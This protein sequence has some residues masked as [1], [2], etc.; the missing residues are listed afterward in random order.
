MK[1]RIFS[2]LLGT[3]AWCGIAQAQDVSIPLV[4]VGDAWSWGGKATQGVANPN[5]TAG[6]GCSATT[7]AQFAVTGYAAIGFNTSDANY[8]AY[9]SD[10]T[11]YDKVEF[12]IYSDVAGS[13]SSTVGI[14]GYTT[15]NVEIDAAGALSPTALVANQ[16]QI[17]TFVIP[18]SLIDKN[19]NSY[20]S[21]GDAT[22][23]LN[24]FVIQTSFNSGNIYIGAI[25]VKEKSAK[26]PTS[27]SLTPTSVSMIT[28]KTFTVTPTI[29]PSDASVTLNFTSS[30]T[31]ASVDA[32]GNVT[33]V[34]AG[35]ATITAT[36]AIAPSVSATTS[37]TISNPISTDSKVYSD[38][39]N[40]NAYASAWGTPTI[41]VVANPSKTTDNSSDSVLSVAGCIQWGAASF[42]MIDVNKINKISFWVYSATDIADFALKVGLN[43]SIDNT[44]SKAL[45]AGTWTKFE[46]NI[47]SQVFTSLTDKNVFYIQNAADGA[48]TTG[49]NFLIDDIQLIAGSSFTAVSSF[50][51]DGTGNKSSLSQTATLQMVT[52]NVLPAGVTNSS[53]VWSVSDPKVATI[54]ASTGLLTAVALGSVTVSAQADG[55]GVI[56]K[57]VIVIA[58]QTVAVT[59]VSFDKTTATITTNGGTLSLTATVAPT[60]ATNQAVTYTVSDA[61]LAT[62]TDKGVVTAKANGTV[63]VTATTTDGSFKATSVIVI[64]GQTI[65]VTSVAFDKATAAISTKGGSVQLTATVAPATATDKTVTYKVSD[66]SKATVSATGVVTA[67]ANGTVTVT[68]TTDD[69]AKTATSVIT[70]TNQET[71]VSLVEGSKLRQI[72][73]VFTFEGTAKLIN[74]IG[75]VVA[76]A[77]NTLDASSVAPGIYFIVIDG[78]AKEVLVK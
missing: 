11:K 49:Y 18:A 6:V 69:G 61:T 27:I 29:L 67:K 52:K 78:N 32:G 71:V 9:V 35:S 59:G 8:S 17:V 13:L 20:T 24:H 48:L 5:T 68:A 55:G 64:S 36:S 54:D 47:T 39:D 43:S 65:A 60:D 42:T 58:D 25:T 30:S 70:I 2:L 45:I 50:E 40:S 44:I 37:V 19:G 21:L 76:T 75:Q 4:S 1:K 16:W 33:S 31:S 38:F 12:L 51:I 62:V 3:L 22:L 15:A 23:N 57:K 77:T 28:N 26:A 34:S 53:V 56:A 10:W 46:W 63:T 66:E 14:K 41:K 74:L 72:G 7:V 73:N